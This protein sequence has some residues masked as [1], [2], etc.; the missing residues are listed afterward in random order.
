[1]E[2]SSDQVAPRAMHR[3]DAGCADA[4]DRVG[5]ER[6]PVDRERDGLPDAFVVE[7]VA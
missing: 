1:M 7:A 3:N 6:G 2:S 4:V 5:H